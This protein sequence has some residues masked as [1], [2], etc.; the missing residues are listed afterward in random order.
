MTSKALRARF[1]A[2]FIGYLLKSR[3]GEMQM[4]CQSCIA[5][6]FFADYTVAETV[7][8]NRQPN[9]NRTAEWKQRQPVGD[10]MI[11]GVTNCRIRRR[12]FFGHMLE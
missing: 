9:A 4:Y 7:S 6:V 2:V 12:R 1:R 3:V 11:S 5:R 8:A 10:E